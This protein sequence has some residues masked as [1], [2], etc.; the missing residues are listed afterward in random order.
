M[1]DNQCPTVVTKQNSDIVVGYLLSSSSFL[2]TEEKVI[3]YVYTKQ[4]Q[5]E[6]GFK[7]IVNIKIIVNKCIVSD[8]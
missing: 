5:V 3:L 7:I 1:S 6:D 8:R 4:R 2:C